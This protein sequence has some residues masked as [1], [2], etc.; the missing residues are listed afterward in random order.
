MAKKMVNDALATLLKAGTT[1]RDAADHEGVT[2]YQARKVAQALK[3]A[4]IVEVAPC[5]DPR[6]P[7]TRSDIIK[8]LRRGFT[9]LGG[10][11]AKFGT[12]EAA[13]KTVVGHLEESGYN[14]LW[15]GSRVRILKEYPK[16][17]ARLV[18]AAPLTGRVYQFGVISDSHLCSKYAR[19]DVLEDA[20]DEFEALSIKDVF[21]CGNIIDGH[22]HFNRFE[23]HCHGITDQAHYLLDHYPQRPGITTHFVTGTCHEGWW[24]KREGL[25]VGRYLNMEAQGRGRTDLHYLGFQEADVELLDPKTK[26]SS[27]LR[28]MHPGGGSSYA[29]SYA[30][31]KII[32]SLQGGEKPAVLLCGHFHKAIYHTVRNVHCIQAGCAQDQTPWMRGKRIAAH[33]G[34]W[35]VSLQQD[36]K[37]AVR[38]ITPSFYN[39]FDRSY[40]VKVSI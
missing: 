31:Q 11:A 22:T 32:E 36:K 35:A 3:G 15:D 29:L 7:L 34:F 17:G 23:L 9:Q 5:L 40:H 16:P 6:D 8:T 26:L 20:Y 25:D 33:V 13:M 12:S 10:L 14:V 24:Y 2:Y 39:Y 21:H 18:C 4:G 38:K 28:V 27:I 30:S 37:G 1:I 19:Q